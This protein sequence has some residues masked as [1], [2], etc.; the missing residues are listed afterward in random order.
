MVY[1]TVCMYKVSVLERID[2]L[3]KVS[4]QKPYCYILSVQRHLVVKRGNVT[5][6][7]LSGSWC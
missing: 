5:M 6:N 3:I 7:N 4:D 2:I 1:E